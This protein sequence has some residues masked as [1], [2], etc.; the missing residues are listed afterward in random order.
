[1]IEIQDMKGTG[2]E[3][4][5]QAMTM[6]GM[7]E[8]IVMVEI[9]VESVI[10]IENIL[11]TGTVT[12]TET[13]TATVT[14]RES[15]TVTVTGTEKTERGMLIIIGI[16]TA[17]WTMKMNGKGGGLQRVTLTVS[18]EYHKRRNIVQDQGM[19]IMGRDGGLT[20]NNGI[21]CSFY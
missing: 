10:W 17:K 18:H 9:L 21:L 11:E 15:V 6:T 7:K 14:V 19:M 8:G 5:M 13:E 16:R 20:L 2:L 4:K 12:E 1:M 3:K